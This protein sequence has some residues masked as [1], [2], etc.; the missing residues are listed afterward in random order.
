VAGLGG[1]LGI[2]G[3]DQLLRLGELLLA[4]Q[5][6]AAEIGDRRQA[7][8]LAPQLGEPGWGGGCVG[9]RQ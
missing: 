7:V 6:L 1:E 8:M 4:L 5:Q 3:A 2:I 9:G